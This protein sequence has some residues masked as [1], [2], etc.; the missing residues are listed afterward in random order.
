[1]RA[2]AQ[3]PGGVLHGRDHLGMLA[4]AEIVVGAPDGDF[5]GVSGIVA[6]QRL[7]E[8]AHNAL[9]VGEHAIALFGAQGVDRIFE[10]ATVIHEYVSSPRL[11]AGADRES[12]TPETG[13]DRMATP[14]EVPRTL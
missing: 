11:L 3:P 2:R 4:H 5:A 8:L 7:G 6:M 10:N 9:E 14:R 12:R 13:L 1:A